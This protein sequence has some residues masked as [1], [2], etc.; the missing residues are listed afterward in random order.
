MYRTNHGGLIE[1]L[2]EIPRTLFLAMGDLQIAPGH[3]LADGIAP[4]QAVGIG[5][6]DLV[7]TLGE[8]CHQF[9][10]PVVVLAH[11]AVVHAL[12]FAF[13][14]GHQAMRCLA[15]KERLF[16][17]GRAHFFLMFEVVATDAENATYR[18][19]F[20]RTGDGQRGNIPGRDNVVGAHDFS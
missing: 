3:V 16:T 11:Q 5:R 1:I 8:H 19:A 12:V 2:A 17:F 6:L 18:K 4:D 10:F 7:A 13:I 14:D 20:A 9:G 15:E